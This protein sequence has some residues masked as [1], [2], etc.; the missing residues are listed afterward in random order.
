MT[1]APRGNGGPSC[2]PVPIDGLCYIDM[3]P[4]N[5]V[6][7]WARV[8]RTG[9]CWIWT[10]T[11]T[12]QGYGA[13][14]ARLDGV[15]V[16]GAHRVGYTLLMGPIPVGLVLDHLCRNPPCVNPVHLEPVTAYVNTHV[17]GI[18]RNT[19]LVACPQGHPYTEAN[20]YLRPDSGFRDCRTCRNDA[21]ARYNATHREQRNERKRAARRACASV[22]S[23]A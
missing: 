17:R 12:K 15:T 2:V 4:A 6:K 5:L 20:T 3:Y 1:K 11:R 22:D 8:D 9:S 7:F 13:S 10:G 14:N 16:Y 21:A 23:P 18:H 19:L